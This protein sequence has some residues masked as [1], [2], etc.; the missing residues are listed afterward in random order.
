MKLPARLDELTIY[1]GALKLESTVARTR[2]EDF[3][4][5]LKEPNTPEAE[6]KG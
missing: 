5:F 2:P 1:H 4:Y 6:E 3:V